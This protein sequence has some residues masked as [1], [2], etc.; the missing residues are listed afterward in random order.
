MRLPDFDETL[1]QHVD[2]GDL[3]T[4]LERVEEHV[5]DYSVVLGV[6]AS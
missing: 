3:F 5:L 2:M 6:Y 1:S 4:E